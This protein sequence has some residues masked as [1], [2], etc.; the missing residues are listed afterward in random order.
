M[1]T[2]ADGC[3]EERAVT[4]AESAHACTL[5]GPALALRPVIHFGHELSWFTLLARRHHDD[6]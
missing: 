3:P 1:R 5:L 4:G 2:A 6:R